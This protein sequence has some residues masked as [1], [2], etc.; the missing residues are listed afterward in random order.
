MHH[1]LRG[2]APELCGQ[3]RQR[4]ERKAEPFGSEISRAIR[5]S[6]HIGG[7][8]V[9]PG[10]KVLRRRD[11]HARVAVAGP[12][13]FQ[14]HRSAGLPSFGNNHS[15]A[16]LAGFGRIG[17]H[18]QQDVKGFSRF[19]Q[20]LEV[21]F[22]FDGQRVRWDDDGADAV[23]TCGSRAYAGHR[24][25]HGEGVTVHHHFLA[26]GQERRRLRQ[27]GHCRPFVDVR[28]PGIRLDRKANHVR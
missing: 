12:V 11:D 26:G 15:N 18:P 28:L 23:H 6:L 9:A 10:G 27:K 1:A 21:L 17:V 2:F 20:I 19:G 25:E 7:D 5:G 22:R 8:L 4:L 14:R 13:E 16:R 24:G 3:T